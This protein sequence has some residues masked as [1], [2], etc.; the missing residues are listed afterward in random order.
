MFTNKTHLYLTIANSDAD[1]EQDDQSSRRLIR[2][3]REL[4]AESVEPN[5][6]ANAHTVIKSDAFTLG[7]LALVAVTL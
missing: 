2:Q 3:L 6:K 7:A 1:A 5:A 4:G